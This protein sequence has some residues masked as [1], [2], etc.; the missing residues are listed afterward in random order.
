MRENL[1]QVTF[2]DLRYH[3]LTLSSSTVDIVT[4]LDMTLLLEIARLDLLADR[5]PHLIGRPPYLLVREELSLG[6][7]LPTKS[8]QP[9]HLEYPESPPSLLRLHPQVAPG[10]TFQEVVPDRL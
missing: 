3:L 8:M 4:M 1:K 7:P 6:P 2:F 5:T 10:L 9:P